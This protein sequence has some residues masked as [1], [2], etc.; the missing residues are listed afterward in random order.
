MRWFTHNNL[1][2]LSV[3]TMLTTGW[4]TVGPGVGSAVAQSRIR[5]SNKGH[6]RTL[7]PLELAKINGAAP[8]H[9]LSL[10]PNSG[11]AFPWEGIFPT[12]DGGANTGNGNKLTEIPIVGWTARGGL[13][14]SLSVFHN[15][16]GNHNSEL[17][18]K[19]S[20]SYD[21]YL[22]IDSFTGNAAI[23]WG[24][25]LTYTFTKNIDGSFSAPAGIYDQLTLSGG[26]YT[27]KNKSQVSYTFTTIGTEVVVATIKDRSNNTVI[28]NHNANAYVTSVVD[29]T[30]RTLSFTY[31]VNNRI[32]TVTDPMAHVFSFSY[33]GVGDLTQITFPSVAAG[34]PTALFG[35]NAAHDITSYTDLRGKVWTN[36]YFSDDSIKTQTDPLLNTTTY[37]YA[38]GAT[39]VTDPLGNAFTHNYTSWK[40]ASIMVPGGATWSYHYDSSLNKINVTNPLSHVTNFTYD[41]MGN[42]LTSTDPLGH[43]ATATYNSNNDVVTATSALGNVVTYSYDGFGR[44]TGISDPLSHNTTYTL[45]SYGLVTAATDALGHVQS[46]GYDTNGNC[47][48]TTDALSNASTWTYNTLG[49]QTSKTD[50]TG[51]TTSKTYDNLVRVVSITAPGGRTTTYTHD[52]AGNRI[53]TTDPLSHVETYS[54]DN[55]GRLITHKDALNRIVSFGYDSTN[56]RNKFTDGRGKITNYY[57]T[58][59]G[60]LATVSF[61]D[62]TS[63]SYTYDAAGRRVT[64]TDGRGVVATNTYDGESRLTGIAYSDGTAGVAVAYDSD[65]RKTSMTDGTGTTSYSY[66]NA[67]RLTL[68]T[69]PAGSVTYSF[70]NANRMTSRTVAGTSITSFSFDNAN[71]LTDVIAPNSENTNYAYDAAGRKLTTTFANGATETNT[72]SPTTGELTQVWHKTAGAATISKSIYTYN[73][74]GLRTTETVDSGAV[75]SL[76]YD[77]EGQLTSESRTAGPSYTIG[78]TYD[79][80]GNRL[81]KTT[82]GTPENYTYDNGSKLLTAGSKSYSYDSAGNVTAVSVAGTAISTL[83]WDAESRLKSTTVAAGTFN[84]GYNGI[85]QRVTKS[86]PGVS[87]T[88]VLSDDAID[89]NMLSDGSASYVQ[90][91]GLIS[92][93]RSGTSK[94][95]HDD[96]HGTTRAMTNISGTTTDSL[97]TDAFGMKVSGSGTTPTPFG[98]IGKSGYQ[99]DS[100]TGLMRVGHRMYDSSTGRFLSRDPIQDGY[101][102]YIYCENDPVNFDDPEGLQKATPEFDFGG[103]LKKIIGI[104]SGLATPF[105]GPFA[106]WLSLLPYA[107][108][109]LIDHFLPKKGDKPTVPPPGLTPNPGGKDPFALTPPYDIITG[110][111]GS[112]IKS[113]ITGNPGS[114]IGSPITGGAP[115]SITGGIINNPIILPQ[116]APGTKGKVKVTDPKTGVILEYEWGPAWPGCSC[117][118]RR[119][120][121]KNCR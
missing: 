17:G 121:S 95:Y 44:L 53:K 59:R 46:Y 80:A 94:F 106:P 99:Q 116:P 54:Y 62:G 30:G 39:T 98:F 57:Y 107:T 101:N 4:L 21:I 34:T 114:V 14:V 24:N 75:I 1:R 27:L 65:D 84:Y 93:S 92:E 67:N 70:D 72:Y 119:G 110:N 33:N 32:S 90:G 83:A 118:S 115:G 87:A 64:R 2:R 40:L 104:G 26:I 86:G 38:G 102:W 19:W 51:K 96:V 8:V 47:I 7:T 74:D 35:Y 63:Q 91:N 100:E 43:V 12:P 60:Q 120:C 37:S 56:R 41:S 85:G 31:D 22:V 16:E 49:Y 97:E 113:P 25:D 36:T 29:P 20:H 18:Q 112:I 66:D 111:P 88:Y 79:S 76:G 89:S 69:A 68:R 23:H 105:L 5:N 11:P 61:P 103:G 50:A 117:P 108:D 15:S 55:A 71:R 109:P 45:N 10:A 28:V 78:Y 42:T 3:L 81:T 58:N 82:N 73:N 6:Q 9:L 13:P 77:A 52:L 48:S